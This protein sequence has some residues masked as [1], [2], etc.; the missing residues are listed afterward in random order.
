MPPALE[1]A[2][3]YETGSFSASVLR[4]LRARARNE[5]YFVVQILSIIKQWRSN[6]HT[7]PY[8]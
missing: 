7:T 6:Y 3:R 2:Q 8:D 4:N 5:K 1:N